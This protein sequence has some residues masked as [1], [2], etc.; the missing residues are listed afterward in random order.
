MHLRSL[1]TRLILQFF[2]VTLVAVALSGAVYLRRRAH[3]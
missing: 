1:R 3:P 2:A